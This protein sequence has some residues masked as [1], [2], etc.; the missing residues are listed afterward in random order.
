MTVLVMCTVNLKSSIVDT[1]QRGNHAHLLMLMWYRV[2]PTKNIYSTQNCYME[3]SFVPWNFQICGIVILACVQGKKGPVA[4]PRTWTVS[5]QF[6]V[7]LLTAVNLTLL[8]L[9]CLFVPNVCTC[10]SPSKC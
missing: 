10:S 1:M 9:Y 7:G 2:V 3:A 6:K 5:S 4:A 8:F